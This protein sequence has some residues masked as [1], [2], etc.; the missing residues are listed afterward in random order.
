MVLK[1]NR[2]KREYKFI[3]LENGMKV[4]IIKADEESVEAACAL[5]V[6]VGSLSDPP[7][8]QG[9]AHFVE[10]MYCMGS[11]K[12]P[13]ENSFGKFITQNAGY[14]NAE[15][16][17]E[18]TTYI[19]EIEKDSFEEALDRFSQCICAPVFDSNAISREITAVDS[20]F[21]MAVDSDHWRRE[22][23]LL[24]TIEE[25][26][27]LHRFI[28]G[29]SETLNPEQGLREAAME[30]HE[31]YYSAN[32]M[33]M[34]VYVPGVQM[35]IIEGWVK[36]Y[37]SQILNK[38]VTMPY[39]TYQ[40][41]DISNKGKYFAVVPAKQRKYLEL[42]WTL[43][44]LWNYYKSRPD[45][46]LNGL[47]GHES[48]G[49]IIY[50]LKEQGL[51]TALQ[52]GPGLEHTASCY[53]L[54]VSI[55][56]TDKGL[57]NIWTVVS[58]VFAYL[59]MLKNNI[60]TH[61]YEELKQVREIEFE[62]YEKIEPLDYCS[63]VSKAMQH[64]PH[65]R[66]LTAGI[67]DLIEE[68][69]PEDIQ[70]LLTYI[71]FERCRI[72]I[73][74]P[75]FETNFQDNH[76]GIHYTVKE[77]PQLDKLEFTELSF[78]TVNEFIPQNFEVIETPTSAP[79]KV[80]ESEMLESWHNTDSS[81]SDCRANAY[82]ALMIPEFSTSVE[83]AVMADIIIN[84]IQ[85][86]VNEEFGYLAY[87]AGY[88]INFSIVDSAFQIH[89][90]GFSHKISSLVE[91]VM[92]HIYNFR[93]KASSIPIVLE[94]LTQKYKNAHQNPR[95]QAMNCLKIFLKHYTYFPSH[96]F[97][98]IGSIAE[99]E[100]EYNLAQV[101][102]LLFVS[103]NTPRSEVEGLSEFIDGLINAAEGKRVTEV[104]PR[105]IVLLPENV[106]EWN[107]NSVN[108]D[109]ANSVLIMYWQFGQGSLE[110]RVMAQLLEQI[111]EEDAF[112]TLRTEQQLGYEV[113]VNSRNFA[114][115]AGL[116]FKICS[117]DYNPSVLAQKTHEFL[118]EA[119]QSIE[120][121][122]HAYRKSLI[123]KK[124][125]PW[126]NLGEKSH[127]YWH[128]IKQGHYEFSRREKEIEFLKELTL[129]KFKEWLESKKIL[130]KG[131]VIKL[132]AEKWGPVEDKYT[133]QFLT[134]PQSFRSNF[135]TYSWM[136]IMH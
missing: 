57:Q 9:L 18:A 25:S 55:T 98:T 115:V 24:H 8:M 11:K 2:D 27:P 3:Q 37:F 46:Y 86:S 109:S 118:S 1:S 129:G 93:P 106:I 41:P 54:N 131:L 30:F 32:L 96:K 135:P 43:P 42:S 132:F 69:I 82:I 110:E 6:G 7:E 52:S 124:K 103:G 26:H 128:E 104:S 100:L 23:F 111:L 91:R 78:P 79:E 58:T 70:H 83:R 64:F 16:M 72:E 125:E 121:D 90:S 50:Y 136:R 116:Y 130:Q 60:C 114:G 61:F 33:N 36:K 40:V 119:L 133:E 134:D 59:D 17:L 10:H 38:N 126:H 67:F 107:I 105:T 35:D 99:N 29:N 76:F 21:R 22:H 4:L 73:R 15:T 97:N 20:E 75:D 66:V 123:S 12:Y 62:Y 28:W 53:T 49:S 74:A 88:M 63:D 81:F 94:K 108:P 45:C 65:E 44:P 48:Q 71:S 101:K 34:V 51:A 14:T 5:T 92:E 77:I 120:E 47:L 117:A 13:E 112:D 89:I 87:E 113:S 95:T 102:I 56:L 68:C 19:F 122:F 84:L 39:S 80:Y 31:H 127:F 85:N